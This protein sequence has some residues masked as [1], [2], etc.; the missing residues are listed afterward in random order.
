MFVKIIKPEKVAKFVGVAVAGMLAGFGQS[1]GSWIGKKTIKF[2]TGG[3]DEETKGCKA[4]QKDN[5]KMFDLKEEE[6]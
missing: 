6:D 3:N 4:K 1:Y 5:F 2:V